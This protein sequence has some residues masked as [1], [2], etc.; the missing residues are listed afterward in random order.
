M[1]SR[2]N[3]KFV[4]LLV[5]ALVLVGGGVAATAFFILFKSASQLHSLAQEKLKT[6]DLVNAD[7]FMSKAV[8][9]ERTNS[10]YMR[11]WIE[12][13]KKLELKSQTEFENKYRTNFVPAQRQLAVLLRNDVERRSPVPGC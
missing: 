5:T 1:A 8:A 12:I 6:G 3:T 2:V 7:K 11:E 9:K 10:G 13:M 4:A